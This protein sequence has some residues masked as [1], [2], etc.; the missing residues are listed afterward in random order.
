MIA[1]KFLCRLLLEI[2]EKIRADIE[3]W[4]ETSNQMSERTE[5]NSF[6]YVVWERAKSGTVE[7]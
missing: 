5:M 4:I 1:Y 3:I 6:Y 2:I 7:T